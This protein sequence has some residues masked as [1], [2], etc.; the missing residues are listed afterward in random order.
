MRV[1]EIVDLILIDC[2]AS[3]AQQRGTPQIPGYKSL[4]IT[5]YRSYA[6]GASDIADVVPQIK[7]MIEDTAR[8]FESVTFSHGNGRIGGVHIDAQVTDAD[9]LMALGM[10]KEIVAEEVKKYDGI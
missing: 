6:N 2:K 3:I 9:I 4:D 5:T 1:G 8:V 10:V 7:R